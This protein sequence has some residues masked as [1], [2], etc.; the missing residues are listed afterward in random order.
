MSKLYLFIIW[1]KSIN[2]KDLILE[3]IEKKFVIRDVYEIKWSEKEFANNMTKFYGRR[4]PNTSKKIESSGIGPFLLILISDPNPKLERRMLDDMNEV[5][6]NTNVYNSKMKYR[7]WAGADYALHA[8]NSEEETK[9]DLALLFGTKLEEFEKELPEKWDRSIKKIDNHHIIGHNGWKN[10]KEFFNVLNVTINYVVL[11]N[12][13]DFPDKIPDGDIDIL[14][15]DIKTMS[16]II[17]Q[18]NPDVDLPIIIGNK[19]ISIDFRYQMGYKLDEKWSKDVLKRRVMHGGGFYVPCKK[20]YFYTLFYHNIIDGSMKY[21]KMLSQLAI[22]IGIE[23]N[24]NEILNDNVESER[25]LKKYM[26]SMGYKK[27]NTTSKTLYKIKH[28]E[29]IRLLRASIFFIKTHG[30]IFFLKKVK[31]KIKLMKDNI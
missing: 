12:F 13:E 31:Q 28:N 18:E 23:E 6:I 27:T 7:A 30:I 22:E 16:I 20:D 8:S 9:H 24:I 4:L 15:D 21:K 5:E 1:K 11:R 3:D 10:T 14:T 25:F 29:L 26:I 2:K 17:N 19:K